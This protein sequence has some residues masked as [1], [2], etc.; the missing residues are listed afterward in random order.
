MSKCEH[1]GKIGHTT[2]FVDRDMVTRIYCQECYSTYWF[3]EE[4]WHEGNQNK[5]N[6]K[7]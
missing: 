6:R 2:S 3:D 7:I 1:C 5:S 4:K